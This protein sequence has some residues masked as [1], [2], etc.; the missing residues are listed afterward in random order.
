M[1]SST[2]GLSMS[3][4]YLCGG[5]RTNC[6]LMLSG[7]YLGTVGEDKQA[8]EKGSGKFRD[9]SVWIEELNTSKELS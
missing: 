9:P 1:K 2:W 4:N 6:C 5:T 3:S 8:K 7:K